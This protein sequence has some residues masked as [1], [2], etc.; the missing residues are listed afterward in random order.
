[1]SSV[2]AFDFG[3]SS[4]KAYRGKLLDGRLH[5]EEVHR[6]ANQPVRVNGHLY[7]DILQLFQQIK[8]GLLKTK[9]EGEYPAAI[10]IDSWAVDFGLLD[11]TGELLGNPY[12]YRDRRTDGVMQEVFAQIPRTEIF[13]RTGIQFLPFNTLYQLYALRKT[14]PGQLEKA[15]DLLMI[16]AL[17]RY[18]LTGEKHNEFSNATTTQFYNPQIGG[19]DTE[20]LRRLQLPEKLM[21]PILPP[22]SRAGVL[23]Q[24]ICRELGVPSIPVIAVAE[25]DTG[26]AVAAIPTDQEDFVYLSCGTW[27]LMGTEQRQALINQQ[28]LAANFTNEGGAG[29]TFRLLKNI[30]GLWILQECI[31][32]WETE[33]SNTSYEQLLDRAA[34]ADA[35]ACFIDPDHPSFLHPE[36]MPA[37]IMQYCL[38]TGQQPPANTGA[39]VRCVLE[40][41]ALKYRYILERTEQ[42]TGK[43]YNGLHIVGGGIHNKLLCQFTAN[44]IGRPVWAGPVEASAIGNI[45]LQ[46]IALGQIADLASGRNMVKASFPV[47]V[48]QPAEQRDWENAYQR[49]LDITGL[50]RSEERG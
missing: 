19:W 45:L 38:E 36:Q 2:L 5:I 31:R 20:L 34:A 27:S 8:W 23:Q 37:Q 28:V 4:G 46:M 17:F 32:A 33:G 10:G 48:Y 44:A 3:A 13:H 16:P 26:S 18:F 21:G 6:F 35:F 14:N 9:Q 1:M 42:L 24:E 29:Q 41:L 40:S 47:T 39:T 49:F 25:H 7:W 30:M 11:E 22:G 15:T 50:L 12:H 43:R